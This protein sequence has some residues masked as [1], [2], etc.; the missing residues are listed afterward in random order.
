MRRPLLFAALSSLSFACQ[1]EEPPSAEPVASAEAPIVNGELDTG[2]PGVVALTIQGQQFC[3]GTL[4]TPTVVVSAAHCI[5]P[6]TG[7]SPGTLAQ[8]FFGNVV[9]Q[10]G[11]FIDVVEAEY[12]PDWFLDDPDADDD[13]SVLRLAS[14]APVAPIPMGTLPPPGSTITLVGFGI[15]SAGG[16]GSGVKRVTQA[17]ID[18]IGSKIFSMP[19][20][21]SGTCNGDSGGTALFL[22]NGVEKLVGIHTRSDCQSFMLDERVDAHLEEFIQPFID[23]GGSCDADGSCASGCAAPDPDCPCAGDGFCTTACPA[24]ATDPDCDP[25]CA[26]NGVCATDCPAPDPDCPVC[27]ADGECVAA[28]EADPDCSTGDGG[29]GGAGG[30]GGDEE[31]DADED[32]DPLVIDSGCGC[33]LPGTEPAPRSPAWLVALGLLLR[34]RRTTRSLR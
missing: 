12:K 4:V 22:D 2:H 9:G 34:R 32:D 8:V 23:K 5:H 3:T 19:V 10:G 25:A 27:V 18:Q 31:D 6:S 28:C 26:A 16:T 24:V 30:A 15:T 20:D 29:S 11:T 14:P 17:T 7:V 1:V 33:A 13:V 21:P